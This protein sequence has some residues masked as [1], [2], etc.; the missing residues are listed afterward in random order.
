MVPQ[1]QI[2]NLLFDLGGVIIN[3]DVPATWQAFQNLAAPN[4]NSEQLNF[5][6]Q[7]DFLKEYE[8]GKI[9]SIEF[10]NQLKIILGKDVKTEVLIQSWNAMLLDIPQSRLKLLTELKKK[11]RIFLL[12]NTNEL[13]YQ[14]FQKILLNTHHCASL[15]FFFI[16]PII[17]TS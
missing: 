9:S 17:H 4:T 14:A 2:K 10:L 12:S 6:W 1:E 3:L 16:T 11:Y 7:M 13:H 5:D 8:V 15:D